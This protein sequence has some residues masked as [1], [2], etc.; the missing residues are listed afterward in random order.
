MV[1]IHSNIEMSWN[2][3]FKVWPPFKVTPGAEKGASDWG[4]GGRLWSRAWAASVSDVEGGVSG[5]EGACDT[6]DGASDVEEGDA[7]VGS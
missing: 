5:D 7:D 1:D 2:V 3:N 6:E 4:G